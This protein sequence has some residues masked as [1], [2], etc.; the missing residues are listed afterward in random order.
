M[1]V[2]TAHDLSQIRRL[3]SHL[4]TIRCHENLRQLAMT[5][6][7]S[8]FSDTWSPCQSCSETPSSSSPPQHNP[9]STAPHVLP[10]QLR[11]PAQDPLPTRPLQELPVQTL[12]RHLIPH[13]SRV[14]IYLMKVNG[15][16]K[17]RLYLCVTLSEGWS[18]RLRWGE[19]KGEPSG[20]EHSWLCR[21]PVSASRLCH[22]NRSCEAAPQDKEE[23][24]YCVTTGGAVSQIMSSQWE[25]E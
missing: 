25:K 20:A 2:S 19:S 7:V 23:S 3:R 9:Q 16:G 15:S 17:H 13:G 10:Q 21:R 1:L 24:G 6:T 14:V 12:S 4:S 18:R 8:I 11:S 5:T 22:Q